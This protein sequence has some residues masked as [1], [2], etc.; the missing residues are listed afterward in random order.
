MAEWQPMETAPKD[1]THVL[2]YDHASAEVCEAYYRAEHDT[3]D[4][5]WCRAN[6]TPMDEDSVLLEVTHWQ[7]LPIPPAGAE[8]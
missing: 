6:P 4:S 7:P 5:C 8:G 1:W 3:N 2:V